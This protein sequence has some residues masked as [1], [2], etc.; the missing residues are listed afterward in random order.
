MSLRADAKE[1]ATA[2]GWVR[3]Q[4]PSLNRM[5]V[6]HG[7]MMSAMIR[8][9]SGAMSLR[10]DAQEIAT[11]S[12]WVRSQNTNMSRKTVELRPRLLPAVVH[13]EMVSAMIRRISGAMSLRADAKETA[14]ANG[15]VR[16]QNPSLNRMAVVH[17]EMMSAMIRRISGAMSL[18]ADAKEIATASGWVRSQ[19]P[20]LNR[21]AVVHGEMMSAMIRRI[22]G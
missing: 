13:G 3:S 22:S 8:R 20:S 19:N 5:A 10:A 21:M 18:R 11:A 7:E 9:I 16:S 17:G 4:N 2:N 14:T 12:G 1:I 15:W 6:V